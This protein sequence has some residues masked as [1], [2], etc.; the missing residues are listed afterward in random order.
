M[1]LP[2]LWCQARGRP[3]DKKR[4]FPEVYPLLSEPALGAF[5]RAAEIRSVWSYAEPI[6]HRWVRRLWPNPLLPAA[7]D[8]ARAKPPAPAVRRLADESFLDETKAAVRE[9]ME[10]LPNGGPRVHP[11]A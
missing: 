11:L 8:A 10:L 7:L 2:T 5:R 1:L 9:L 6:A 4:S 3:V